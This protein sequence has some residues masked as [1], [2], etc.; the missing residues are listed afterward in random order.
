MVAWRR[1]KR[2]AK[3]M[4]M[5]DKI[6][7]VKLLQVLIAVALVCVLA[8]V[9]QLFLAPSASSRVAQIEDVS[10]LLAL[11]Q[12]IPSQS[13]GAVSGQL[14]AFDSLASARSRLEALTRTS[15]QGATSKQL[16]DDVLA[17]TKTVL[18]ARDPMTAVV[19]TATDT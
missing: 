19:K 9:A 12:R 10:E 11:S 7:S 3:V 1:P 8:A 4:Y 14:R 17:Q 2:R 13:V 6:N 16:I 15:D 5:S 18:T